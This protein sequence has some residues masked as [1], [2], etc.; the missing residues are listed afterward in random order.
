MKNN[1]KDFS[2]SKIK[3]F[4]LGNKKKLILILC[5]ALLWMAALIA[6]LIPNF[7]HWLLVSFN[8]LRSDPI[9]APICYY[10]TRYMLYAIGTPLA[11][12]Y[13]ASFKI[14][15]LKPYRMVLLLAVMTMAIGIPIVDLLKYYS[16][17]PRPWV[18]YPDIISLYR[19][20]G[21]SFPSG[22]AFQAFAATLPIITCFLS[23]DGNLKRNW[24]KN[25]LVI[26]LLAFAI[27]LS[28]S[29]IFAGMHFISDVLFGIGL[30]IILMVILASMLEWLSDTGYLNLQNEKYYAIIFVVLI[31]IGI[32]FL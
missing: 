19:G 12:L 27:T 8:T 10:Y 30:A 6:Y 4:E 31:F 22:H 28:F 17:V 14:N 15:K 2:N 11:I 24:K 13:L 3:P 23:N 32:I 5:T 1:S 26:I 21:T 18:L 9:L 25:V 7:N 29:R 16:A 20:R